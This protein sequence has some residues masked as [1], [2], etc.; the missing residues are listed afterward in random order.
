MSPGDGMDIVLHCEK[1][2]DEMNSLLQNQLPLCYVE[3]A[4]VHPR[5]PSQMRVTLRDTMNPETKYTITGRRA[6]FV[7]REFFEVT[8]RVGSCPP[9]PVRDIDDADAGLLGVAWRNGKCTGIYA[10]PPKRPRLTGPDQ[11]VS[12][13]CV[14]HRTRRLNSFEPG[15]GPCPR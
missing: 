6:G 15:C 3:Q 4:I 2:T 7:S 13:P 11:A 9:S 14:S 10:S 12:S 5:H 8:E 1:E